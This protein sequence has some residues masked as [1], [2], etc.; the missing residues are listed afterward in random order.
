MGVDIMRF[1]GFGAGNEMTEEIRSLRLPSI[2]ATPTEIT[3]QQDQNRNIEEAPTPRLFGNPVRA[4]GDTDWEEIFMASIWNG[5]TY[6]YR[7][8]RVLGAYDVIAWHSNR[9]YFFNQSPPSLFLTVIYDIMQRSGVRPLFPRISF[10]SSVDTI[11]FEWYWIDEH[12]PNFTEEIT[13]SAFIT[14]SRL[15]GDEMQ[16]PSN[17]RYIAS[18]TIDNE[19]RYVTSH[20]YRN[21]F[22][23]EVP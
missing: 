15:S 10:I 1:T 20:N 13:V 2:W 23:R 14:D 9:E 19:W 5:R 18:L 22:E 7:T 4:N 11:Q 16:L 17:Q 8:G 3:I 21:L 12:D 6:R